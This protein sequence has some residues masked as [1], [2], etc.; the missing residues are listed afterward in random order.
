ML[1]W[2]RRNWC[3][4]RAAIAQPILIA[5]QNV[6]KL[7]GAVQVA[8][9]ILFMAAQVHAGEIEPGT[10]VNT[11]VG[12]N[13]LL[14]GYVYSDGGLSTE[15]SS[16]IKDAQVKMHTGV[17]AYARS[18]DVWGKSGKFDVILP[19]SDLSGTATVSGQPRER[20]V[21]GLTTHACVSRSISMAPLLCRWKN[22][23]TI[24]RI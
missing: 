7:S 10:Y 1:N 5:Y 21:S 6:I 12:I 22:L 18:L 14:M 9:A 19:Y 3:F 16:P 2:N 17:L 11:P 15:T 13:F 4:F 20:N 8:I 23:P 24:S